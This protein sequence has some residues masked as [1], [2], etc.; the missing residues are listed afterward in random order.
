VNRRSGSLWQH[1]NFLKLWAGQ[2]A[3]L[4]GSQI[5]VLA[6]PLLAANVLQATPQQMG[7]L[8]FVQY[9]PWLLVGLFAGV[10]VDRLHR[11]P[12]MLT[13]DIVRVI[14]LSLIPLTAMLGLIRIEYLYLVGFLVGICNVFFEIAY[15]AILP[16]LIARDQLMEGNSK[17][18]AS[19]SASEAGGPGLA[20]VLVQA[21]S[22]PLAIGLDAL[23]FAISALSLAWIK[24]QEFLP[25]T[26]SKHPPVLNQAWKGLRLSLRHPLLR[27]FIGCSTTGNLFIDIHLA[28]YVLYLVRELDLSPAIIGLVYTFGGVGGVIGASIADRLTRSLGTG[29]AIVLSQ[30]CHG[31]CM[32][33]LP[34]VAL[35]QPTVPLLAFVHAVWGLTSATY[36]VPALSLRQAIT[37][38]HLQGRVT[39]SQRVL[40]FGVSPLGF[41][42]GGFFGT[43]IGL[44]PTLI[45]AGVGLIFS[46][47][48]LSL[49]PL[50]RIQEQNSVP[51]ELAIAEV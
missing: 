49:S 26:S 16:S 13:A 20:G 46:N 41:L 30:L 39:A 31:L 42:I 6:L 21:I 34:L 9:V 17:L 8:G 43:W 48:W 4:F 36:A 23:S 47:L 5:T 7:I 32:T 14:L 10:W 3:S 1:A 24:V 25:T 29:R 22:A 28:V 11:R 18:Q 50:P 33:A 37:P 38:D 19:I 35:L 51:Q 12:I 44:W 15:M 27:G 40:T 2:T 45:V